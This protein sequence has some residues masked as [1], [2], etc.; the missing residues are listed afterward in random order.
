MLFGDLVRITDA[1]LEHH[2]IALIDD[3][4]GILVMGERATPLYS[5]PMNEI[6][7]L[8]TVAL[9]DQAGRPA[10]AV[11]AAVNID[12]LQD[13]DA[14]AGELVQ[15]LLMQRMVS[16]PDTSLLLVTAIGD[17]DLRRFGLTL[18]RALAND[19]PM[20][21]FLSIMQRADLVHGTRDGQIL[22]TVSLLSAAP[23]PMPPPRPWWK[24]W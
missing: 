10:S 7:E 23:K 17:F 24:F 8:K 5:I 19:A 22:G 21:A 11:M 3:H 20:K 6:V 13:L 2:V 16:P 14:F 9:K 4:R 18:R 12:D 1:R 15:K